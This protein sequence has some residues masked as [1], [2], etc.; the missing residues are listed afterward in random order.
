MKNSNIVKL[1]RTTVQEYLPMLTHRGV[2]SNYDNLPK[3]DEI[4]QK[5]KERLK[6]DQL[7]LEQERKVLSE[8]GRYKSKAY[9]IRDYGDYV[10]AFTAKLYLE[11][12][13]KTE[14]ELKDEV[15]LGKVW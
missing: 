5:E 10:I 11:N 4:L 12:L 7:T 1:D 13:M 6:V 8:V 9:V 15:L 3:K 2:F 14:Q